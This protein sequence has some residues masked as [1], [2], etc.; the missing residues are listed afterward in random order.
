W[1][2]RG[3]CGW[4]GDLGNRRLGR[5]GGFLAKDAQV[6]HLLARGQDGKGKG[7]ASHITTDLLPS[8][9]QGCWLGRKGVYS[10]QQ[11]ASWRSR[12]RCRCLVGD[13][14]ATGGPTQQA[15]LG[16][17]DSVNELVYPPTDTHGIEGCDA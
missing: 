7:L 13:S 3:L 14:C 4:V 8:R 11:A 6:G 5:G 17:S 15:L 16:S 9:G 10:Q 12:R 1:T 2:I